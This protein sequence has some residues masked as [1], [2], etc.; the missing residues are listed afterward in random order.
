M[1]LNILRVSYKDCIFNYETSKDEFTAL[2]IAIPSYLHDMN[3]YEAKTRKIRQTIENLVEV[4]Q[5]GSLNRCGYLWK[6][7]NGFG[8]VWHI[9]YVTVINQQFKFYKVRGDIIE[10]RGTIDLLTASVK[11]D[12]ESGR[13]NCLRITDPKF[14]WVFQ[15]TDSAEADRWIATIKENVSYSLDHHDD[16]KKPS[17]TRQEA[18]CADCGGQCPT[19]C[20]INWGTSICIHCSGIH[21]SLGVNVS[22]VRSLTLD[23]L[24]PDLTALMNNIGNDKANSVLLSGS[25]PAED[26]PR[27]ELIKAKYIDL[28]FMEKCNDDIYEM[29]EKRDFAGVMKCV[30]SGQLKSPSNRISYYD[31]VMKTHGHADGNASQY[32]TIHPLHVA[33]ASGDVQIMLLIALN[34]DNL[35]VFDIGEWTPLAYAVYHKK[36]P[37]VNA[38]MKLGA[39]PGKH[40][41]TGNPYHIAIIN[42]DRELAALFLPF[43]TGDTTPTK[44]VPPVNLIS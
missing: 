20:C 29:I 16:G 43:W 37:V 42:N 4:N 21:R 2:Q 32:N 31:H 7:G 40:G 38:L 23:K 39:D 30:F 3:S 6:R 24:D 14:S 1:F 9:R 13:P 17:E 15:C 11:K 12:V 5:E 41:K 19:W 44:L 26:M 25:K 35:N 28:A 10:D 36:T 33:A 34:T 18:T 22:K 27:D 8:K